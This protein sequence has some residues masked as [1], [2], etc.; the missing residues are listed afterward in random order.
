M[1]NLTI[2]YARLPPTHLQLLL[3]PARFGRLARQ[4]GKALQDIRVGSAQAA[5]SDTH[6]VGSGIGNQGLNLKAG[7]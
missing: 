2:E 3:Q 1:G 6:G 7:L 5:N 4:N